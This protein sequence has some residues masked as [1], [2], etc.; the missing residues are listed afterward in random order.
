MT[1]NHVGVRGGI[2]LVVKPPLRRAAIEALTVIGAG[3]YEAIFLNLPR[4]LQQYVSKLAEEGDVEGFI[5]VAKTGSGLFESYLTA[6]IRGHEGFLR[7]LPRVSVGREVICYSSNPTDEE[8]RAALDLPSL[9]LRDSVTMTVSIDRWLSL[10]EE[11]VESAE[12]KL[13]EEVD[14]LIREAA[15]FKSSACI[16]DPAAAVSLKKHLQKRAPTRILYTALPYR[17]TPLQTLLRLYSQKPPP[18]SEVE[19]H[20]KQHLKLVKKY[21]IP[22]GLEEGLESWTAHELRWLTGQTQ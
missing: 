9:I 14:F 4:C 2:D 3:E 15:R 1:Q 7:L 16:C 11:M 19:K 18:V 22:L 12:S 10:I 8:I 17:F 20:I 5:E 6:L 21:V 13:E